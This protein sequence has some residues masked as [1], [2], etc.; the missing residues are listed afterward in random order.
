MRKR[1]MIYALIILLVVIMVTVIL[2]LLN[3]LRKPETEIREYILML[4]PLDTNMD[5]VIKI[6]ESNKKWK[7]EW[8]SNKHGYGMDKRGNIGE[9]DHA[10][11]GVQSMRVY[12]GKYGSIF[13]TG[14]IAYFGFDE[15]SKLI[16]IAVRKDKDSI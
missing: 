10:Y 5:D 12:L 3:P 7:I 9:Y 11:V 16:D 15:N 8:T 14:V 4:T 6:V 1:T 13:Q 2:S